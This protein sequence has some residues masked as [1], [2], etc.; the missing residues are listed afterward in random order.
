MNIII[1]PKIHSIVDVITN[2]STELFVTDQNQTVNAIREFLDAMATLFGREHGV[3]KIYQLTEENIGEF[4]S[5]YYFNYGMD[6]SKSLPAPIEYSGFRKKF[7]L[8]N[9]LEYKPY[10]KENSD[11]NF[12]ISEQIDGAFDDYINDYKNKNIEILNRDLIGRV[13]I[14]GESSNT[15][16]YAF[17]EIIRDKFNANNWY[18]G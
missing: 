1:L 9:K 15:I 11:Y 16:P 12:S 3:G 18:L 5:D 8:D 7:L 17:W 13:V 2:S 10:L 6:L 14:I 4:L